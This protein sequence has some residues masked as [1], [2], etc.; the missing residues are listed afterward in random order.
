MIDSTNTYGASLKPPHNSQN[1]WSQ[2]TSYEKATEK[3]KNKKKRAT[4]KLLKNRKRENW[5]ESH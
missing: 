1:V 3:Q 2:R 4:R 5:K